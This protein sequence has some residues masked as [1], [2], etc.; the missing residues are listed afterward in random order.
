VTGRDIV[1]VPGAWMGAWV[2]AEVAARL[3][4][5]EHRPHLIT[6]DGL[7]PSPPAAG[8]SLQRHVEQVV[9][10]LE[11]ADLHDAVLVGHSYSGMVVGQVADTLP[12]RV[13]HSIHFESF[14]PRDGRSLLDDWGPNAAA[15]QAEI[16]AIAR[17]GAWAHPVATELAGE[18]DLDEAQRRWL[19]GGFSPHPART[20]LDPA[21][22][23]WPVEQQSATCVVSLARPGDAL[24]EH[25]EHLQNE[26]TWTVRTVV[27]GHWPMVSRP[28]DVADL[29]SEAS[30]HDPVATR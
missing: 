30:R 1:L 19:L 5:L 3:G 24:P 9:D 11:G 17:A 7:F 10:L 22:M 8:V 27:A 16:D 6:L 4:T 12:A 20:V 23:T 2:W 15:R 29:I 28:S 14:L 21:R 18:Q 26:P 13:L 25:A